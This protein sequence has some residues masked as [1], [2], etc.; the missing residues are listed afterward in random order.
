MKFFDVQFFPLEKCFFPHFQHSQ[1]SF[2]WKIYQEISF[3]NTY[4]NRSRNLDTC[5]AHPCNHRNYT[6][7]LSDY[8][9]TYFHL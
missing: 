8:R 6:I 2:E 1:I 4:H 5:L 7:S 3:I 9:L